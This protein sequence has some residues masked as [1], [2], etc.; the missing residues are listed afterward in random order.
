MGFTRVEVA[1]CNPADLTKRRKIK[2][3]VDTGAIY[4]VVP[5][6]MLNDIKIEPRGR[7]KFRLADGRMI[8]RD[9][10]VAIVEYKGFVGGISV[11]FG[12]PEDEPILGATA[13]EALGLE[14]DPV[15]KKLK[16]AVLLM[17]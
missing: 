2:I 12:D 15:T 8:E 6:G 16:P 17:V 10:G 4:T 14:V 5:R 7:R 9:V 1:I 3:L 11:V 13:L